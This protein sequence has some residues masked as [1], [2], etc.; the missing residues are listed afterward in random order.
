MWISNTMLRL[1]VL[2]GCGL[3]GPLN[4]D[5]ITL[6]GGSQLTGSVRSINEA[7][8]MELASDLTPEPILLKKG[9]VDK[10]TFSSQGAVPNPPASCVEL[11]NGDLL[12]VTLEAFNDGKLTVVSPEAGRLEIPRESVKSLQL[13]ILKRTLIYAG[14]NNL[15]EWSTKE[16]EAKNWIFERNS[17]ISNGQAT[18]S[19]NLPLPQQFILRFT[20]RWQARQMPNFQIFFADPLKAK[21]NPSDRYYLQ[22]GGAG[23]EIKR[24]SASGNRYI[25]IVRLDKRKPDMYPEHQLQVELRVNRRDT[26][27][28]LLL[29]GESEG[30]FRDPVRVVPDGSGITL[31]CNSP[32]GNPQEISDI[33]VLEYDDSRDDT[34]AEKRDDLKTDSLIT[35]KNDRWSGHLMEIRKTDDAQVFIF[36]SDFKKDVLEIPATD[37]STVFFA[38]K[39]AAIAEQAGHSLVLRIRGGGALRVSSCQ[40]SDDTVSAVHPLLGKLKILRQGILA[41]ERMDAKSVAPER[42]DPKPKPKIPP[43]P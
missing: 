37:F 11:A 13:G 26:R 30:K 17:L 20:L 42:T 10:V 39:G 5:N 25:T 16:G 21:D 40:F 4:A 27:L 24:E 23:L 19:K 18:A 8:V 43:G 3:S 41:M 29:N 33:E 35:R 14:P 38:E 28:H 32:S 9:T 2:C 12:P 31:V 22:F 15:A 34:L 7:G 1:S 36:K 6:G